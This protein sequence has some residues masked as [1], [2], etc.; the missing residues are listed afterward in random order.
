M[1]TAAAMH[2][3]FTDMKNHIFQYINKQLPVNENHQKI[4]LV[5]CYGMSMAASIKMNSDKIN[6][7]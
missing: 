6:L 5:I 3:L 4:Y 7:N 2:D 1:C